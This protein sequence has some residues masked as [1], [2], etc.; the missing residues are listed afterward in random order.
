[1]KQERAV[2]PSNAVT[3]GRATLNSR[4]HVC[5]FFGSRGDEYDVLLPFMKEGFGAGDRAI[6]ILEEGHH[7]ER[8]RRL[9]EL[10]VDADVVVQ[11]GLLEIRSWENA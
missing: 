6:H 7:S 3:L 4:C 2:T 11:N 9:T 5:A 1:M 8:M 10:G